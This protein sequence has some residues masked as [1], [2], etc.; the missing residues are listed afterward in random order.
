LGIATH[1]SEERIY[2]ALGLMQEAPLKFEPASDILNG[3]VLC[4]LPALLAVGLLNRTREIFP[5]AKGFYPMESI[6]MAIAFLALARVKSLEKLR[7][8]SPGEWGALLGLDRLPEVKTLREKIRM[9]CHDPEKSAAW[10]AGLAK[11]WL[12]A[13]DHHQG[14]YYVDGHVRVYHG[15]LANRPKA[16]VAREQ[17]CLRAT[18]DYWVNAMDGMPFFMVT[19]ALDPG[20]AEVIQKTIL[21]RLLADAPGQP[22]ASALQENRFLHRLIV[23]FD[24]EAFN[25]EFFR[26]LKEDRVAII[27]YAKYPGPDW[28]LE[29]FQ[30]LP[31]K[32]VNG[33]TADLSIAERGTCLSNGLWVRE[34][35]HRDKRG[36]Q[37]AI[38][39]TDYTHSQD[40]IASSM[41]ARWCQEN[42]FKYMLE[43]YSLDRLV[44]YGAQPLP[45]TAEVVNPAFRQ[46]ENQINKESRLMSQEKVKFTVKK[47]PKDPSSKQMAEFETKKGELLLSIEKRGAKLLELRAQRKSIPKHVLQ[48]DLPTEQRFTKLPEASKHFVDTIK[49]IAY[50]AET[51]LAQI[52]REKM[53]REEDARGLVCQILKSSVNLIPDPE[54]NVLRIQVHPLTTHAHTDVLAHLC[55]QLNRTETT[56]PMTDLRLKF[57]ILG[58]N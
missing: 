26:Q 38:Y 57:E 53:G 25:L 13:N 18:M 11:D 15:N 10:S 33:E 47:L 20:L 17:L 48:K 58:P 5:W 2:A 42:F 34:V 40:K 56:Y 46:I 8:E 7:Y 14:V 12:A 19:Q 27:T 9:L 24:R 44:E 45:D 30:H 6:F 37:T 32:L 3:G 35:R 31:V 49:L 16:Y 36:H 28:P 51:A 4:A 39:S 23:V 41:F 29:E 50:R 54:K 21:P 1:R 22:S 55:E 43:H 52:A